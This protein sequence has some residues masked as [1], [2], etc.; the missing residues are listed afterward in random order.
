MLHGAVV[1]AGP[2][3]L[4]SFPRLDG[5][6]LVQVLVYVF[7][8]PPHV[9]LHFDSDQSVYP[10]LIAF[11]KKHDTKLNLFLVVHALFVIRK[12]SAKL[13]HSKLFNLDLHWIFL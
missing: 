2:S 5:G 11:K 8:P 13:Q 1:F 9:L 4:Q 3:S 7:T 12:S 10:P 6:G